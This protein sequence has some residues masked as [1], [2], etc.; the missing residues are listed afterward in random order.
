MTS[1][2]YFGRCNRDPIRLSSRRVERL[3][4]PTSIPSFIG[5]PWRH[6]RL[7]ATIVGWRL[8]NEVD[9]FLRVHRRRSV[10]PTQLL[11]CFVD[12][13]PYPYF[14]CRCFFVSSVSAV[15]LARS[16]LWSVF[17]FV[18]SSVV[19]GWQGS[20]WRVVSGCTAG[21]AELRR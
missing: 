11:R 2:R 7:N 9:E 19:V 15:A 5:N 14:P 12:G 4:I 1:R 20:E 13:G 3:A 8:G 16:F 18:D 6:Q 21:L 17:S 10:A